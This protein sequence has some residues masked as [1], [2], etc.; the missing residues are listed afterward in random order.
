[1]TQ[2]VSKLKGLNMAGVEAG[3]DQEDP[4]YTPESPEEA[5]QVAALDAALPA[6]VRACASRAIKAMC[7]RGRKYD[8]ERAS[9]L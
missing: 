3:D 9:A 5:A 8:I 4:L 7:L 6:D 2:V 1:M